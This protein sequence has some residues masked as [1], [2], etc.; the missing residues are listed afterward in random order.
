MIFRRADF[1]S[2][3]QPPADKSKL[4]GLYVLLC[5]CVIEAVKFGSEGR[6][7]RIDIGGACRG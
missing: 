4:F 3:R 6:C 1:P 5:D 7:I 2:G